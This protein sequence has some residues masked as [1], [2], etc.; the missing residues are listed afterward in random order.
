M[1]FQPNQYPPP[2]VIPADQTTFF[3]RVRRSIDTPE[4]YNEFLKLIN[5]FTQD[6]IDMRLL[7]EQ[8]RNFIREPDLM[9]QFREILGWDDQRERDSFRGMVGPGTGGVS[10]GVAKGAKGRTVRSDMTV[11]CGPSYRRL[12]ASVSSSST[13]VPCIDAFL[14]VAGGECSMLRS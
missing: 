2:T 9:M 5:L 10:N 8:S 6:I 1:H 13:R 4:T 3:D 11:K 7:V 14:S 12:P